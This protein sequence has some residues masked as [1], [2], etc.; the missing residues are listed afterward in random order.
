MSKQTICV[1]WNL[2]FLL[3][4][5]SAF[6]QKEIEQDVFTSYNAVK[7]YHWYLFFVLILISFIHAQTI[8]WCIQKTHIS[9]AICNEHLRA[10]SAPGSQYN[11][12]RYGAV[13]RIPNHNPKAWKN[14]PLRLYIIEGIWLGIRC[15]YIG[16]FC[17]FV[18]GLG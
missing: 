5:A 6:K 4:S 1:L 7:H 3:Q 8:S 14:F 11:W 17:W 13:S 2:R 9:M 15:I 12:F 16:L 10:R 18:L